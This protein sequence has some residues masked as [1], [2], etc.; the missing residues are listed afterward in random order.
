M[1]AMLVLALLVLT[2]GGAMAQESKASVLDLPFA[3][4]MKGE[5][6]GTH[7]ITVE[8][9]DAQN[10][11]VS[12]A[13]DLEVTFGFIPI[14]GYSHRAQEVWVNGALARLDSTTKENGDDTFVHLQRTADGKLAGESSKG[15][16]S[17]PGWLIPTS[18]WN[19]ALT[20]Q[21][22]ILNSQDGSEMAVSIE[23]EGPETVSVF[24]QPVV[25]EKYA[26]TGDLR[27]QLWYDGDDRLVKLSFERGGRPIDYVLEPP[28]KTV[29]TQ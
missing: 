16:P 24:G 22:R 8:R 15:P 25:A 21:S 7:A 19:R 20:K 14:F 28:A 5:R 9:L 17:L 11:H 26:M 10:T 27:L 29:A 4:Y 6:I 3:V 13:I 12:V 2:S 23:S 1:R 18:Y